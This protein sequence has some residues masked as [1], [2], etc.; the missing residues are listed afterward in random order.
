MGSIEWAEHLEE[1]KRLADWRA[2]KAENP[3]IKEH[4]VVDGRPSQEAT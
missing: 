3:H 4:F 2:G 1:E